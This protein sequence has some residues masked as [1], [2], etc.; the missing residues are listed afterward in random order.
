M[1]SIALPKEPKQEDYAED[2][3]FARLVCPT[4]CGG[5]NYPRHKGQVIQVDANGLATCTNC[6]FTWRP[7]VKR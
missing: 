7:N 2:Y 1:L 3:A 6:S 5:E 4:G